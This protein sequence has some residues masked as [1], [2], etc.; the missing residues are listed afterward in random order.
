M[1]GRSSGGTKLQKN[2]YITCSAIRNIRNPERGVIKGQSPPKNKGVPVYP[3]TPMPTG[4]FPIQFHYVEGVHREC[5]KNLA[6]SAS[7]ETIAL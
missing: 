5:K 6:G 4:Q 2:L 1:A 3:E 7:D